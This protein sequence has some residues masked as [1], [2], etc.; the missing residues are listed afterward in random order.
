MKRHTI[1]C[2]TTPHS[3]TTLYLTGT[4]DGWEWGELRDI[5]S[6]LTQ[7]KQALAKS[8]EGIGPGELPDISVSSRFVDD[9]KASPPLVA[10]SYGGL[11]DTQPGATINVYAP[12]WHA[13]P[14]DRFERWA[15]ITRYMVGSSRNAPQIVP[16]P[17]D[18]PFH[19]HVIANVLEGPI[20]AVADEEIWIRPGWQIAHVEFLPDAYPAPQVTINGRTPAQIE[21]MESDMRARG[22]PEWLID[23]S[24]G[25]QSAQDKAHDDRV[26]FLLR[27]R[28]ARGAGPR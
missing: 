3:W 12:V 28:A 5:G 17:G 15:S 11:L 4:E 22:L 27:K 26:R 21:R 6:L 13:E 2:R 19:G 18:F 14:R 7:H 20:N 24:L 9:V 8:L 25:R 10:Q 1:I 23:K 16:K